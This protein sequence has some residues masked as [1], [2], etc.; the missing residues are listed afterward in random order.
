MSLFLEEIS[1]L[2][3]GEDF[4]VRYSL[5]RINPGEKVHRLQTI[6]KVLS[7]MDDDP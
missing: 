1:G 2:K 4:K 7:G 3:C 6:V 5:E